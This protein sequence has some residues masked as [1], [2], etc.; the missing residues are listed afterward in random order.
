MARTAAATKS[1][2]ST[3]TASISHPTTRYAEDV[4]AGRVVAGPHV[5]A[6]CARH[7]R[8]L[9]HG[10]KR[11]LRFDEASA[12]YAIGYFENVLKLAGGDFEGRPFKLEPSQIFI[13][14][15]MFGWLKENGKRRFR[16]CYV[17][18]G[19]GNG[20]SPIA[21][22]IGLLCLT[23]DGEARAE[24]YAAATMKDQAMVLFRDAVAMVD[25]S[26]GLRQNI[27][28]TGRLEKC[29]NLY[30]SKSK[31]F[32]RVIA[33]DTAQSGPRP[34]C[35]LLDEIH[36]HKNNYIIEMITAGFK[37]RTQPILVMITNSGHDRTSACWEQHEYGIKVCDGTI[38]DDS[39][40][41][42]IC[43]LD[44]KEDPFEDESCWVKA[45]PLLGVTVDMEYLRQQVKQAR[46]MPSK[47]SIV[48]RL[49]FCQWT[50]AHNPLFRL[51]FWDECKRDFKL[52]KFRGRSV[53]I[54]LDLSN[55][56]DL[57]AAVIECRIKGRCY[58]W[59]L[60]WLPKALL[61]ERTKKDKV[62]YEAWHRQKFLRTTPGRAIDKDFIV[63]DLAR[64]ADKFDLI[65]E[66]IIYDRW[67]IEVFKGACNRQGVHWEM[68]PH[69][70]GFAQ[71]APSISAVESSMARGSIAH[72]GNPALRMCVANAVALSDPAGNR[73]FDKA[74]AS[75][76]IDGIVA[77]TMA[78]SRTVAAPDEDEADEFLR[79]PV[80]A[81]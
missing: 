19:K 7:L 59:P 54:G 79:S 67:G 3:A 1:T 6:A 30:H 4:G 15:S 9:E 48:R 74:K 32:F 26:P 31:S 34:S 50:E 27:V 81:K 71:M 60:F 45:N 63:R 52:S 21:A 64:L 2:P 46:G 16:L 23:S 53:R 76:R 10:H 57:T 42:Y 56:T 51:D 17:E 73:K 5:R 75:G 37:W 12:D 68:A 80:I 36:E 61:H 14:G 49:N 20:K 70:Q 25:Q 66:E 39:Y 22:G 65:V 18:E 55:T 41:A 72:N 11:G 44:E 38:E 28:K 78:H 33:S 40:F 35:G 8:D 43:A 47:E 13:I 69:G 77:A 24:V 29:W 62:P 58:W